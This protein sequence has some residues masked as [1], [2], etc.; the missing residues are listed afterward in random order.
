MSSSDDEW[1]QPVKGGE[2][3]RKR[4]SHEG[5][6]NLK[7][8]ASAFATIMD[9]PEDAPLQLTSSESSKQQPS[10]SKASSVV[11]E[12]K[13][14]KK[15]LGHDENPSVGNDVREDDLKAMAERGVVKLFRAVAVHRRREMEKEASKGIGVTKSGQ[16]RRRRPK[17]IT[18][19]EKTKTM[20][21]FLD[22]L[23][24]AKTPS[25]SQ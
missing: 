18:D 14:E 21:S 9:R 23:K 24:K 13:R 15:V 10:T 4:V 5:E 19:G 11:E 7:G 1:V 6:S 8:F 20:A 3:K 25:S 12:S 22:A 16:I 17:P 2:K